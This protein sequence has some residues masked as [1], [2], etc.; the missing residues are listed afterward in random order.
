MSIT[1]LSRAFRYEGLTL[2]DPEPSMTADQ[3]LAHYAKQYPRLLG[4]KVVP[5]VVEGDKHVY[6]L[7]AALAFGEK[8]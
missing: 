7:R 1:T 5:P 3:V 8:G 6:E 4:G 2:P